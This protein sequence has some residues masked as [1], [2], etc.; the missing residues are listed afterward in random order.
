[1]RAHTHT[2]NKGCSPLFKILIVAI[3]LDPSN[4]SRGH[5]FHFQLGKQASAANYFLRIAQ[6]YV[7]ESRLKPRYFDFRCHVPFKALT[8]LTTVELQ[9]T[10][11]LSLLKQTYCFTHGFVGQ[12]FRKGMAGQFSLGV[13]LVATVRC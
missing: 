1:M 5:I 6:L 12:K 13:S 8:P 4:I 3:L 11:K 7:N 9:I 10:P 2:Q